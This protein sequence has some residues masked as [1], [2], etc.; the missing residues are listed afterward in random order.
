VVPQQPTTIAAFLIVLP[1]FLLLFVP[2]SALLL[3]GIAR[4]SGHRFPVAKQVGVYAV[5]GPAIGTM[6]ALVAFAINKLGNGQSAEAAKALA[7]FPMALPFG[8]LL[9]TA[10]AASSG[11]W[12]AK[13][14]SARPSLIAALLK[15]TLVTSVY[16]LALVS[17]L[18]RDR[19]TD[20]LMLFLLPEMA[21]T[22]I[23]W[24]VARRWSNFV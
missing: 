15:A 13:D 16:G 24:N 21:S 11:L 2:G 10:P 19:I 18:P 23:C 5:L 22:T 8:Y 12:I 4:R 6:A 7:S 1:V 9:G 17:V 3:F 20:F 14:W